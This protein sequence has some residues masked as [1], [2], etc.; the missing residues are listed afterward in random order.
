MTNDEI[1][2]IE[3][4]RYQTCIEL[5]WEDNVRDI[6]FLIGGNQ[7]NAAETLDEIISWGRQVNYKRE[8]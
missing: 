6:F 7:E 3:P 8:A 1:M 2:E 4:E 5:G